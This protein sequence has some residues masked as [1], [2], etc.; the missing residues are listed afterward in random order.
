MKNYTTQGQ[1]VHITDVSMRKENGYG[2]YSFKAQFE[3]N[4]EKHETSQHSTDSQLYDEMREQDD[5]PSNFL[6]N[7]IPVIIGRMIDEHV[8]N[9]AV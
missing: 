2:Q 8:S 5:N 1:E 3:I 4:G 6:L 9:L 7:A